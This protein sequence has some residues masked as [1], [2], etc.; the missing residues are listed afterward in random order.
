MSKITKNPS[1]IRNFFS[2]KRR[3]AVID[4]FTH[5][6]ESVNL[7]CHSFIRGTNQYFPTSL[8]TY[9]SSQPISARTV[10]GLHYWD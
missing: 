9:V 4:S 3:S 2:K 6:L 1:E 10:G 7:D 5:L 8:Q